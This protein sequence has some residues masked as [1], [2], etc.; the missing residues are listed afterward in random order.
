MDD[1]YV[2]RPIDHIRVNC[3][4]C[5]RSTCDY[6]DRAFVCMECG[7][8]FCTA[9]QRGRVDVSECL[10]CAASCSE[11]GCAKRG[12]NRNGCTECRAFLALRAAAQTV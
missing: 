4:V 9:C 6:C 3:S 2:P 12:V 7:R 10:E 1:Y 11:C 5:E 8:G